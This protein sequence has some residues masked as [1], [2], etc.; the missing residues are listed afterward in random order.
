MRNNIELDASGQHYRQ[1]PGEGNS[2]GQVKFL[3]PNHFNVYLHDTPAQ[4][5]FNRIERDF[6]H[7]CVR[8]SHPTDLAKY[9]LRDQP[10]WTED[11]IA[12]AMSSGVSVALKRPLRLLIN[13]TAWESGFADASDV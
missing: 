12:E 6:S 1:R 13:F 11:R 4:A 3:F 5:L 10:E 2:L 7:G 8:L 9:L